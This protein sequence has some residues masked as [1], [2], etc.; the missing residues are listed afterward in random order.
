VNPDTW[1]YLIAAGIPAALLVAASTI[2]V[3]RRRDQED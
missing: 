1:T 2:L 3:R